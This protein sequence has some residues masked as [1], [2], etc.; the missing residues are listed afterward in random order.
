MQWRQEESTGGFEQIELDKIARIATAKA[1][2]LEQIAFQIQYPLAPEVHATILRGN[3]GTTPL[4]LR[5]MQVRTAKTAHKRTK[6]QYLAEMGRCQTA[7][8]AASC[9]PKIESEIIR[10]TIQYPQRPPKTPRAEAK[11]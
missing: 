2:R 6:M 3:H 10:G 1:A 7:E 11:L 9:M 8:R 5:K 4:Y